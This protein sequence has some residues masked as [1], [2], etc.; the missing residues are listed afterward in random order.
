MPHCIPRTDREIAAQDARM[1]AEVLK[2]P[3]SYN[4]PKAAVDAL[5]A[6]T[7]GQPIVDA[8]GVHLLVRAALSV[9]LA[10]EIISARE[11]RP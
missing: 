2:H 4:F 8:G 5:A 11:A 6:I 10:C 7:D 1:A 3:V 9:V